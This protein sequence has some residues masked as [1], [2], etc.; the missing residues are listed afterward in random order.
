MWGRFPTGRVSSGRLETGPTPGRGGTTFAAAYEVLAILHGVPEAELPHAG[1]DCYEM[2]RKVDRGEIKGLL[3]WSFNPAVSLPD[4]TC[5]KRMLEKLEFFACTD[6]YLSETAR[7]A[8]V[9]L[10]GSQ[11]EED[12]PTVCSTEGW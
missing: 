12:E 1:V 5:V 7:F 8:D 4:A 11:H 10:P 3:S 2:L 9:V 6:F